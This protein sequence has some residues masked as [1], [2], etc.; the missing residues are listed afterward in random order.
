MAV[1]A[2]DALDGV[3]DGI[4]TEIDACEF[5]AF[6]LIGTHIPC[7]EETVLLSES[8]A[9]IASAAWHGSF[10]SDGVNLWPGVDVV[11]NLTSSWS[12][13]C[14]SNGRCNGL[15]IQL[16]SD[17][18]RLAVKKNPGFDLNSVSHDDFVQ[19]F[20]DSVNEYKSIIGT[21]NSNL[22]GFR[23]R[24]G[25]MLTFHGFVVGSASRRGVGYY[26]H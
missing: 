11:S 23:R 14:S 22:T 16:S 17:C 2:C 15:P 21:D 20:Q 19:I 7:G 25:K 26:H 9:I 12:S 18:I 6:D 4:V 1:R 8:S 3:L 5:D 24:G 13:Q 10:S